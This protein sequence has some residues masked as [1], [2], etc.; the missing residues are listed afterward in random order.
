MASKDVHSGKKKNLF[1]L[2]V[3]DIFKFYLFLGLNSR[4]SKLF[5]LSSVVPM[6]IAVIFKGSQI[7]YGQPRF[8]GLFIYSNMIMMFFLHFLILILTLFFGSSVC[9]EEIEG[10]TLPYLVTR[11]IL[12]M[13]FIIGKYAA[14]TLIVGM[15][16][17]FSLVVSFLILNL[18]HLGEGSIYKI[19][20]RDAGV[21]LIGVMS[22]M[23]F[24]TFLGIILKKAIFFGL[25][26]SF[27]WEN[28]IQYF[29][30]QTQR[31]AIVHYLKSLLPATTQEGFSFLL[32]RLEPTPPAL[33][34]L[35][36]LGIMIFFLGLSCA[37]YAWKEFIIDSK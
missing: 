10:A 21:L 19:L 20:A 3:R 31:F 14:Y 15:T 1:L 30:G 13:A 26:F 33:S 2:S 25:L 34:I 35:T 22:Y 9:R 27:G 16:V 7:L 18:N 6:A 12:K 8:S 29:P 24:F 28:I 4:R 32:F 11:P 37:L 36:L 17:A 5:L 23:A